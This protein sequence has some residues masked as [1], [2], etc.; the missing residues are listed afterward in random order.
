[1]STNECS[2][3][4]ELFATEQVSNC[5]PNHVHKHFRTFS[6]SFSLNSGMKNIIV[7]NQVEFGR[8]AFLQYV[9]Y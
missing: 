3:G 8:S 9:E 4:G 6:D 5:S 2:K 1:M 7:E